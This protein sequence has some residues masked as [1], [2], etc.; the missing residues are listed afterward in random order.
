MK[1]LQDCHTTEINLPDF[2]LDLQSSIIIAVLVGRDNALR[3]VRWENE[4]GSFSA[5]SIVEAI[6]KLIPF[7]ANER[8]IMP[9]NV[10]FPSLLKYHI[11]PRDR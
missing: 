10:L 6:Q 4:D 1:A 5:L 2:T 9:I 11:M 7:Y 8:L 3:T